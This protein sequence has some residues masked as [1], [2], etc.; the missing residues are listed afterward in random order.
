MNEMR[1]ERQRKVIGTLGQEKLKKSAVC[2]IGCG[3]LGCPIALYMVASGVGKITLIDDD[4]VSLSN[5]HRQILFAEK[6]IGLS[7]VAAAKNSLVQLNSHV[8]IVT[9]NDRVTAGNVEKYIQGHDLI[10]IGCDNLP[11]R[12]AINDACCVMHIPFINA[13]VLGD[14][15]AITF[16]DIKNGCYRCLFPDSLSDKVIPP[17]DKIGVL[18]ALVGVIGTSTA[19]MGIEILIGQEANYINK[20]FVFDSLSLEMKSFSFSKDNYCSSCSSDHHTL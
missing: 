4:V 18:G 10:I 16:F 8:E 12:Y 13:S 20:I 2:I 11:T 17:P 19:T 15:G 14:E 6:D 5:L 3:G 7:K 1:Y 9:V